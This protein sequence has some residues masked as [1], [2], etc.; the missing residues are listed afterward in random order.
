MSKDSKKEV[1]KKV[2][3]DNELKV[4]TILEGSAPEQHN[5]KSVSVAG[6]IDSV[7][8]FLKEREGEFDA[9]KAHCIVSVDEGTVELVVNE[10]DHCDT[11]T[12]KGSL[13]LSKQF[14][15]L[16]IN[17][18]KR[19]APLELANKFRLMRSIFE[20]H[21]AHAEICKKLKNLKATV[22][23]E[24]EK[25]KEDNG[26]AKFLFS[27]TVNSNMPK[28]FNLKLPLI[29]GGEKELIEIQVILEADGMDIRCYLSSVEGQEK[30]DELFEKLVKEEADFI[31]TKVLVIFK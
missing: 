3:E 15:D 7:K 9:K 31:Q 27:Q 26:D 28:G 29:K 14:K 12:V 18:S 24:V 11:Y 2:F 8:R 22:N 6:N 19:Y 20:S 30:I 23:Q 16:G 4:V 21:D 1:L 17:T 25:M 13:E 5:L 10:Q